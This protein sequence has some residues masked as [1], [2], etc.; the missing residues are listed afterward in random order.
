M[1]VGL[2]P[3]KKRREHHHPKE[4]GLAL[5]IF[6]VDKKANEGENTTTQGREGRKTATKGKSS[7]GEQ[8][9][10]KKRKA[11]TQQHTSWQN[12]VTES[13]QWDDMDVEMNENTEELS[14]K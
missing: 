4:R 9:S 11:E 3:S 14:F 6:F 7:P 2:F 13:G 5:V 10:Q 1:K 12:D 8:S